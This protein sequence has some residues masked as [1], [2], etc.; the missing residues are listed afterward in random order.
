MRIYTNLKQETKN[1]I[2]VSMLGNKNFLGKHHSDESK[3]K[4]SISAKNRKTKDSLETRKK[5][6]L[7]MLGRTSPIKGKK[8]PKEWKDKIAIANRGRKLPPRTRE[9]IEKLRRANLG[10]IGH[11]NEKHWN[12]KGGINSPK[13]K[14]RQHSRY[15][16]WRKTIYKRDN[17]KCVICGNGGKIEVDHIIPLYAIVECLIEIYGKDSFYEK[18]FN[19]P[20]IWD[21]NNG[22]TLCV[23][24]HSKTETYGEH[25][26][27]QKNRQKAKVFIQLG[28]CLSKKP[29]R[30][31]ADVSAQTG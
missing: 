6:S 24:C 25:T 11:R 26:K 18:I 20:L 9:H 8:L 2:S 27:E 13:E 1:K 12:W 30:S 23:K 28:L 4:M 19:H 5:K 14:I 15:A 31:L 22:R 3:K 21:L 17:Y 7:A 16:S 29:R 10:R